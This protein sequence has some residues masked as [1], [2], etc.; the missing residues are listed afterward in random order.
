MTFSSV[1]DYESKSSYSATITASDGI[2]SSAQ[3][4]SVT[5]NNLNDNSPAFTS[6]SAFAVNENQTSIGTA[7]ASDAD[8]DD[9]ADAFE[10]AIVDADPDDAIDTIA[11]VLPGDDFDNDGSS[12]AEEQ[13]R[14]TNPIAADSDGDG[15][16]DGQEDINQDGVLNANETNPLV[17]DSDGDGIT[18]DVEDLNGNNDPSDDDTDGDGLINGRAH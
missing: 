12:N 4:I 7:A 10:Q 17:S 15:L 6:S 9:L 13:D 5:V 2:N 1:P 8:G 3:I 18:D 14:S 16:T 11:D